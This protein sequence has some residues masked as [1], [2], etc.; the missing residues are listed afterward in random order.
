MAIEQDYVEKIEALL[1]EQ[2]K[3]NIRLK[4]IRLLQSFALLLFI[5]VFTI[6]MVRLN[7]TVNR[8][9]EG[10]PALV[11]TATDS[12]ESTTAELAGLLEEIEAIDFEA[13]GESLEQISLIDFEALAG[14]LEQAGEKIDSLDVE[15]LNE[16][17]QS[18]NAVVERLARIFGV[19]TK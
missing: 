15:T 11:S 6:G 17:I 16:S 14:S 8:A 18:L 4:K 9:T 5:A 19:P 2:H 3:E 1:T 7:L 12:V 10:V 13:L